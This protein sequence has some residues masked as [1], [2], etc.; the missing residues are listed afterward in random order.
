MAALND[1]FN[2]LVKLVL[3]EKQALTDNKN[4]IQLEVMDESAKSPDFF[5]DKNNS[6]KTE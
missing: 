2:E 5:Y 4:Y 3:E 1:Q 6:N